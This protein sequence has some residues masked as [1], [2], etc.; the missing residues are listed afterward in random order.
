MRGT[1]VGPAR[2]LAMIKK[3]QSIRIG[4]DPGWPSGLYFAELTAPGGRIGYAPFVL[5]P[6]KLGGHRIAV[7]LP[8]ETWQA[9]NFRDDDGDGKADTWYA[10]PEHNYEARLIRPFEN[11]GVPPHYRE[12]DEPFL[13]WLE[14]W[15]TRS[16]TSA[17]P[18]CGARRAARSRAPTTCSIFEGHHEYVTSR[19][20]DAVEGYRN[21]GGS[22]MFLSANNFFRKITI[23]DNVMTLVGQYRKLGRPEATLTG[24]RYFAS[25]SSGRNGSPWVVRESE[26]GTWIFA[27]TGLEPGS[28][29]ASG[30]IE[31]DS[32]SPASPPGTEVVAEIPNVFGDGRSAADDLLRGAVGS[33]GVLGRGVHACGRGVAAAGVADDDQPDRRA[34]EAGGGLM[35]QVTGSLSADAAPARDIPRRARD[36]TRRARCHYDDSAAAHAAENAAQGRVLACGLSRPARQLRLLTVKTWGFDGKAHT[37]SSSSTRR[38]PPLEACSRSSTR[39]ASRSGTCSSRTPTGGSGSIPD[40]D[41]TA[42]FECRQASASPC[43]GKTSTGTWSNHAYGLAVDIN[44]YENPYV[45]CGMT[46]D[47]ERLTYTNRGKHAAWDGHARGGGGVSGDRLGLGRVVDRRHQGLHALLLERALARVASTGDRLKAATGAR[48]TG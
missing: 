2:T 9:Y 46:R 19:E 38:R 47:P 3:K 16:T 35:P 31:A 45:G 10:D 34:V 39:C 5:A 12:Y 29:F 14:R 26:A 25:R 42:S 24:A 41:V 44:P 28:T 48:T 36:A 22:L 11:R 7:V 40:T 27:D 17:T 33:A 20:F 18:S 37:G 1:P 4:L 43:T 32:I 13:R 6:E 15:A 21:L 8:T 23:A 30:G